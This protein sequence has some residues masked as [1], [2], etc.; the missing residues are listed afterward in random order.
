MGGLF[1]PGVIGF[2]N[3][4]GSICP[5]SALKEKV[6]AR[7]AGK[8]ADAG[9]GGDERQRKGA[10]RSELP[11]SVRHL[12]QVRMRPCWWPRSGGRSSSRAKRT[13]GSCVRALFRSACHSGGCRSV[14]SS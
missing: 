12:W 6:P 2:G 3:P 10:R 8:V 11:I 7:K 1:L 4:R 13:R 14:R 9:R 5:G